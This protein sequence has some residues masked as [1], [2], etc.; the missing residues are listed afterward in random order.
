MGNPQVTASNKGTN[1]VGV[2]QEVSDAIEKFDQFK[3]RDG[4]NHESTSGS[5][6][7]CLV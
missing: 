1:I 7:Y 5:L 2:Q 3:I 6:I 4:L